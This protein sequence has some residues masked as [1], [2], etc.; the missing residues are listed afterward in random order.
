VELK[1][2]PGELCEPELTLE[3]LEGEA[4]AVGLAVGEPEAG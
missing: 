1:P 4:E 3:E 2:D